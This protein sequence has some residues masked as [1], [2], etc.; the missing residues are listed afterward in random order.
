MAT[1]RGVKMTRILLIATVIG[2]FF[3]VAPVY[4]QKT[5]GNMLLDR[6]GELVKAIDNPTYNA[7]QGKMMYCLGFIEGFYATMSV[8]RTISS[9]SY[10]QYKN[11]SVMGILIPADVTREQLT[12]VLVKWLKD[13][14]KSLNE[15]A[16]MLTFAALIQAFPAPKADL[17]KLAKTAKQ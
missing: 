1:Q 17:Q 6:C 4:A 7:D 2:G 10:E 12:R 3:C 8:Q 15:D 16:D 14:P 13:N 11:M 5:D 9:T